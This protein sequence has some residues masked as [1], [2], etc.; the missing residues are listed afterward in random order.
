MKPPSIRTLQ[1]ERYV[2][3]LRQGGSLPAVIE[4]DDGQ[5]Y[6]MKFAGAGQGPKALIAELISGEIGRSL[7]LN[8]P[9]LVLI[10][11]DPHFGRSE[12]DPEIQDLLQ[13]SV[14]LNLGLAYLPSAVEYSPM[15]KFPVSREEAAN[16]VW[17]DAFVTNVDRTARNVNM[18]IW[19]EQIWLIDHGASLYFHHSWPGYAER[20]ASAFPLSRQHVLLAK[21]GNLAAAD[22]QAKALLAGMD[23]RGLVEMIPAEWLGG[24][25][26]FAD[27]ADQRQAYVD[28]LTARLAGSASFVQEAE[29][30]R[31]GNG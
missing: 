7:G 9:E 10:Q 25:E 22:V 19:Q 1:A 12:P 15:L 6:V 20:A 4:A 30:G 8:V 26:I 21:A 23:W 18:L 5:Q 27:I 14:G 3:P 31:T 2:T 17:F 29:K 24:E 16:I 13:G 11:M 28:Y